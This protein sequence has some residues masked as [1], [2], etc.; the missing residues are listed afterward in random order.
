MVVRRRCWVFWEGGQKG[1]L[2]MVQG[3]GMDPWDALTLFYVVVAVVG[4]F[5]VA[6]VILSGR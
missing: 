4:L 2:L 1:G 3:R 5:F 6:L